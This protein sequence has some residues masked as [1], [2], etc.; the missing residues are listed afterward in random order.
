M[1]QLGKLCLTILLMG[2]LQ[3]FDMPKGWFKAGNQ[4]NKYAVSLD[5]EAMQAGRRAVTLRSLESNINGFGTLMQSVDAKAWLGKRLR[6]KGWMK[7]ADV[8]GR[9]GL[10]MRVDQTGI[11]ASAAFD[12][13]SDRPVE[14][15]TPWTAYEIV[16]DVPTN[17]SAIAFGVMLTGEGQLWLDNVSLEVVGP[18]VSVTQRT[19][20]SKYQLPTEPTNLDF[21]Q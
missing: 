16:L 19:K 11:M 20:P 17:A 21:E 18:E 12:N 14:G 13:M 15:T 2:M 10:W 3:G 1:Q 4:A 5:T 9:A 7:T 8:K 6:M